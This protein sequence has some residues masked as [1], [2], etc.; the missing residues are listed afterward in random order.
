VKRRPGGGHSAPSRRPL[1]AHPAHASWRLER[2]PWRI[3]ARSDRSRGISLGS[4]R[5]TDKMART[6]RALARGRAG[7]RGDDQAVKSEA[8]RMGLRARSATAE[9]TRS[10]VAGRGQTVP[11][12]QKR[13]SVY[14]PPQRPRNRPP[15]QSPSLLPPAVGKV[16]KP[17]SLPL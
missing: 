3:A 5:L 14:R 10:C 4:T 9:T 11:R 7:G 2:T 13:A 12:I 17:G 16:G 1:G 8:G 15:A 6:R